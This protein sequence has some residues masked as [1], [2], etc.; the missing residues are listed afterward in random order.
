[1]LNLTD[2]P[3]GRK[4]LLGDAKQS[5]GGGGGGGGGFV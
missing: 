1:M 4:I 2:H 5:N 3:Q